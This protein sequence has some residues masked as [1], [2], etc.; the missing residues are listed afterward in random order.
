MCCDREAH[1]PPPNPHHSPHSGKKIAKVF[2]GYVCSGE[3][4]G[5]TPF[6]NG[7]FLRVSYSDGTKEDIRTDELDDMIEVR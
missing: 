2:D 3:V 6:Y 5:G 1:S 7:R 4:I